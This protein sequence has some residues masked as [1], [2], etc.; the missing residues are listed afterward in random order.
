MNQSAPA[1][2]RPDAAAAFLSLST[3]RLA[4]WRLTGGGPKYCKVG[5]S[6][7]Y[8]REDLEA[9]LS[10]HSRQSTSDPGQQA[11]ANSNNAE[12]QLRHRERHRNDCDTSGAAC[13]VTADVAAA[14]HG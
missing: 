7:L 9:R 10:A 14:D 13:D 5:R 3:Q 4:K 1:A 2:L 6:I 12:R 8:R 11:E